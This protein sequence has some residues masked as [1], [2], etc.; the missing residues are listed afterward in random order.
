MTVTE[1]E[2]TVSRVVANITSADITKGSSLDVP[3]VVAAIVARRQAGALGIITALQ[4]RPLGTGGLPW[5]PVVG[6]AVAAPKQTG[7]KTELASRTL[8]V[9]GGQVVP[10]L[11]GRAANVS[12][13]AF[14][15][16]GDALTAMVVEDVVL[17]VC[18]SLLASLTAAAGT[19]ATDLAAA[20]AAVEGA[21][22]TPDLILTSASGYLGLG[23]PPAGIPGV[24]VVTG[25][26]S[27]T[28]VAARAG[29]WVETTAPPAQ[30]QVAEPA[31]G[32]YEV[33]ALAG[34]VCEPSTGAVAAVA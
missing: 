15:D 17:G 32:G 13:Q 22:W 19:A 16:A 20:I 30:F 10:D 6:P 26:T 28:L 7:E 11:I 18:E 23:L 1:V 25:P 33:S 8:T 3:A 12:W 2:P 31:I 29:V 4:T 5:V 21:G 27:N 34:V 9:V 14:R 24:E